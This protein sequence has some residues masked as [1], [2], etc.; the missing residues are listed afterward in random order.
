[1]KANYNYLEEQIVGKFIYYCIAG[2]TAKS[3]TWTSKC[4]GKYLEGG[5]AAGGQLVD[6]RLT[7]CG[8]WPRL[9]RRTGFGMPKLVRTRAEREQSGRRAKVDRGSTGLQAGGR[10][11]VL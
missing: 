8:C 1:M 7:A 3:G 10:G 4:I 2:R 6:Q 11:G 9:A 5:E